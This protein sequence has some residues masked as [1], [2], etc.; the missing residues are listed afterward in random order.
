MTPLRATSGCSSDVPNAS[1]AKTVQKMCARFVQVSQVT[2]PD[3][4][5]CTRVFARVRDL[6]LS[7]TECAEGKYKD[8]I[9]TQACRDCPKDTYNPRTNAK[10][11]VN[12]LECPTGATTLG[13]ISQ[14]RLEN[15]HCQEQFYP[16][17]GLDPISGE[18]LDKFTCETCPEGAMCCDFTCALRKTKGDLYPGLSRISGCS[19]NSRCS[20]IPGTWFRDKAND[21]FMLDTCPT[22]HNKQ[23]ASV[24]IAKCLKCKDNFYIVDTN[25]P[26]SRCTRY[27]RRMGRSMIVV[28]KPAHALLT[29]AKLLKWAKGMAAEKFWQLFLHSD[30]KK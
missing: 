16:A 1:K 12:C 15:C 26:K 25:D 11:M 8:I 29:Y 5:V 7:V 14:T 23:N 27:V 22:G 24:D 18:R 20:S 13:E 21:Q 2:Q 10:S 28:V 6:K 19:H 4:C 17:L 3:V 9:G 30:T